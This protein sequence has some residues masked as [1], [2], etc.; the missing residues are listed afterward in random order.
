MYHA[1]KGRLMLDRANE[2]YGFQGVP[3]LMTP[4]V[5]STKFY[6][7]GLQFYDD[8]DENVASKYD[9]ALTHVF[10]DYSISLTSSR[11]CTN[12]RLSRLF[13]LAHVITSLH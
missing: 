5:F 3:R 2:R 13:H 1:F 7:Q 6:N 8:D 10:H 9:F 12:A 4:T 11:L